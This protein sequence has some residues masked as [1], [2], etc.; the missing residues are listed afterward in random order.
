MAAAKPPRISRIVL[1]MLLASLLDKNISNSDLI[2]VVLTIK[3]LKTRAIKVEARIT[4]LVTL[5]TL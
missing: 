1:D 4:S 5:S 2:L 3:G